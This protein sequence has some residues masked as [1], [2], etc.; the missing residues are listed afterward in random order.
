MTFF[1]S[2]SEEPPEANTGFVGGSHCFF[3]FISLTHVDVLGPHDW[4]FL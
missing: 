3:P 2:P 4:L 1:V